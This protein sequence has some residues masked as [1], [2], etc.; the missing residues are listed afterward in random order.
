MY[1]QNKDLKH[2]VNEMMRLNSQFQQKTYML[3]V[4]TDE[5]LN[6][7]QALEDYLKQMEERNNIHKE[8]YM[9][10]LSRGCLAKL[11]LESL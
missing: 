4:E 2:K 8:V 1:A 6:K 7:V 3:E 9:Y 10:T 11:I 5:C